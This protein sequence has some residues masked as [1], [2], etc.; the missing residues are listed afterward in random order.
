MKRIFLVMA[1]A[2]IACLSA[3][4][5]SVAIGDLRV[6][7]MKNPVGI[8]VDQPHFSWKMFSDRRGAR[9]TACQIIVSTGANGKNTVWDSGKIASGLSLYIPYEGD[10]LL[11]STRYTWKVSVWDEAGHETASSDTAYF[12]TGL[13]D[14]GWSGAQ[15]LAFP[16]PAAENAPGDGIPLFRRDFALDGSRTVARARLY[17]S[18]LGVYDV[19]INGQRV[20]IPAAGGTTVY[21]EFKP[22]W[23]D[24]SETVFYTTY[25]V[26]G[27]LR[28]RDNAIGIQVSSGWWNGGI[29]HGDYG[30]LPCAVLA[31]L[32]IE[33]TD[34]TRDMVV[35]GTAD[36]KTSK[37]SALRSGD[38]Y[39]GETY[40][41]RLESRWTSP[42]FNDASWLVPQQ[43]HAFKGSI[44]AFIAPPV[45]V[46]EHLR[47]LPVWIAKYDGVI[48]TSSTFGVLNVVEF[49][50]EP[51]AI[52]LRQG[53]TAVY[54]LGQN[55]VGWVHFKVKGDAGAQMRIRFSEMLNTDGSSAKGNDGPGGSL[56]LINLRGAKATLRY[57]LK[58]DADG[59][60]FHP[61][62][63]FF[64]FR[65]VEV[66][67]S[68]DIELL[69]LEGQVV[70][71]AAEEGASFA[72]SNPAVNKLYGN[73]QWGQRG[74]FLSV[75]TDCP[76]RD[77]RLGWTGDIQVFG[78]AAS[79][80][81]DLAAFFR[82]WMGDMRDDQ[83]DDGAYPNVAPYTWGVGYGASAWAEAGVTT[84]WT[85]YLMYG[86]RGILEENF[87]S[88][89]RY[90]GFLSAQAGDGFRYNGGYTTYGDWVAYV[91]TD[92]RYISVCYHAYAASLM[93]KIARALSRDDSDVYAQKATGYRMLLDSIRVEFQ[94]RYM[95]HRTKV[96]TVNT[97]T[98]YL[99]AL[100]LGMFPDEASREN[101]VRH[102]NKLFTDNGNRL[103]TG[104]L[105]TGILNR[106]LSE[107]GLT[108]MAYNLLLQR[109]N[110]SWLYS[111]DQGAT[112]IWER[113]NSY[114]VENGFHPDIGMNSFNHYAYGAV[115][116]WM[117]SFMAGI[118]PDESD[119]GFRHILLAPLP[120]FRTEIP[121]GQERITSV[122]AS[123]DSYYGR[124]KSAWHINAD[125]SVRYTVT[126]PANAT[127]T[128]T[129]PLRSGN[130][131]VYEDGRPV[132]DAKGV[133]LVRRTDSAVT[134]E[135]LAGTYELRTKN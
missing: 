33:Y 104:F 42:G 30:N 6:E 43:S 130:E 122:D 18:A 90:M 129:L 127:A 63:S 77:E 21:D 94:G 86:D 65:Y 89:E 79:Y 22:G 20:G 16:V 135:L 133:T 35:T 54:D 45:R 70:G 78:R 76:Q 85:A 44:K 116:E 91:E 36:W 126:V 25:D 5:Q 106:T 114:T 84:P 109:D 50:G 29:A 75:P 31:K 98:A 71:T 47:R 1:I 48:A 99:L 59:E 2:V 11:P 102:L 32:V 92:R 15:W 131:Q 39:N 12:E 107:A 41:A 112:T 72:T 121:A 8:D 49:H 51:S 111:V 95:N 13:K 61:S 108:D 40:D 103:N 87:T 23:T 14:A 124:I 37:E 117:F 9:Q 55:M 134:L 67:C 27:L 7:Y 56:Y 96:L 17:S 83:R 69:S 24:Y 46:R 60:A 74:N 81:A 125:G 53:E 68:Q 100:K 118:N 120:D 73:V 93:E 88:M 10:A 128:L 64:G 52:R 132:A 123:Y 3:G 58:G 66:T 34:G 115:S 110:P 28:A 119:P 105:G 57:T 80:N 19:F 82:K 4:S 26:A 101:V 62:S 113:W 97:Q 38:I